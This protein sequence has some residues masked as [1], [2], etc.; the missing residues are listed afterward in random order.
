MFFIKNILLLTIILFVADAAAENRIYVKMPLHQYGLTYRHD[1]P[2][3]MKNTFVGIKKKGDFYLVS[4]FHHLHADVKSEF[5]FL[6]PHHDYLLE[7]WLTSRLESRGM[8]ILGGGYVTYNNVLFYQVVARGAE[9]PAIRMHYVAATRNNGYI[10]FYDG[11]AS[12]NARSAAKQAFARQISSFKFIDPYRPDVRVDKYKTVKRRAYE[13]SIPQDWEILQNDKELRLS[14]NDAEIVLT[15]AANPKAAK[16]NVAKVKKMISSQDKFSLKARQVT[17]IDGWE[18]I[19]MR[20]SKVKHDDTWMRANYLFENI[21][22]DIATQTKKL[23]KYWNLSNKTSKNI[24]KQKNI[25]NKYRKNRN[26]NKKSIRK[27]SG[28]IGFWGSNIGSG[29]IPIVYP[30]TRSPRVV[31]CITPMSVIYDNVSCVP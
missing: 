12:P 28:G 27:L 29:R 7:D 16:Q 24:T 31:R 11:S 20:S 26:I 19:S 23:I 25:Y 3:D 9:E 21:T 5:G 14:L 17:V 1:S 13:L 30:K 6:I 15:F 4:S 18:I 10:L 2:R 22:M 8:S